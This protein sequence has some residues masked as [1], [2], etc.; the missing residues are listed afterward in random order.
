MK[1]ALFEFSNGNKVYVNPDHI[2]Y[3]TMDEFNEGYSN[4]NLQGMTLHVKGEPEDV[5][6]KIENIGNIYINVT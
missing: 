4:L 5:V 1:Y 2:R 6:R 3:I